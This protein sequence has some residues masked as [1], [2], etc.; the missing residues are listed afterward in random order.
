MSERIGI[1]DQCGQ[2]YGDIPDT[3]TA[4]KVKCRLCEGAVVIPALPS[5]AAAPAEAP[6]ES[7]E[8][9]AKAPQ[10]ASQPAEA[11]PPKPVKP[12]AKPVP[13]KPIKPVAKPAPPKPIKPVAKPVP[14]KP[15]KPV[16]KPAPPK[17]IKPVAKPAPPKPIKP[18]AKPAAPKPSSAPAAKP[19]PEKKAAASDIIAKAKA[20]RE[21]EQKK[22]AAKPAAEKKPSAAEIIAKA[23][24]KR[25]AESSKA[26]AAAPDKKP[27]AADIIA[28]AKAKRTGQPAK[29]SAA[30][31]KA[32][33]AAKPRIVSKPKPGT[34][35]RKVMVRDDAGKKPSRASRMREEYREPSK[36]PM[37]VGGIAVLALAGGA[38]WLVWGPKDEDPVEP[39]AEET[40]QLP[41]DATPAGTSPAKPDLPPEGREVSPAAPSSDSSSDAASSLESTSPDAG[42]AEASTPEEAAAP[43]PPPAPASSGEWVL[44]GPGEAIQTRGIRDH[45]LIRL[46]EVPPLE[47]WS[48]TSEEEW[49]DIQEDLTLFLDDSGAMSN[50]AGKRLVEKHP[51]GSFPAIVNAMMQQDFEDEDGQYTLTTLNELLVQIGKNTNLGWDNPKEHEKG[52]DKWADAVLYTKKVVAGWQSRW[53]DRYSVS[54]A[55]WAKFASSAAEEAAK[56]EREKPKANEVIGPEEDPFD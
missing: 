47:K 27:S 16:A 48:G 7:K 21:A 18:V 51:R 38:S 50:R 23:K 56:K 35:R 20:K 11:A 43:T 52:S 30:P 17:P 8:E 15:I 37:I 31:A 49:A 3:V 25:S 4:T 2:R 46:D 55:E 32:A 6:A 40:V 9:Q 33:A 28:K 36:W 54:D 5:P 24:A 26:E 42:E 22:A 34:T 44:P 39:V 45:A 41:Q 12:V 19:A 29:P 14:P 1:C 13:P 53:V 10:T